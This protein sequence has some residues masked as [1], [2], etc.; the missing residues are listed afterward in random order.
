MSYIGNLCYC[1]T[2][3]EFAKLKNDGW[4]EEMIHN[5]PL[6]TDD[7]LTDEQ[8][9]AWL[10][11]RKELVKTLKKLPEA[12][13]DA[14]LVFEYV[15][16][17]HKPGTRRAENERGIRPDVLVVGKGFVTVLEFKQRHLDY[18]GSVFIGFINQANKYVTRLKKYHT[19]CENKDIYSVVVLTLE[20]VF[21]EEF[22]DSLACSADRLAYSLTMLNGDN[23]ET[24]TY[25]EMQEW[26]GG[27]E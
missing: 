17:N 26:L 7:E 18:D 24:L 6:V 10:S 4:M 2:W 19:G 8:C 3:A 21:F 13:K 1:S 20:K 25:K 14:W 5:F 9:R 12:Y 16:P 22:E 11:C 23:P 27:I 15:L